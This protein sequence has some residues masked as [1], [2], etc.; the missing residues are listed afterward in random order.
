[1]VEIEFYYNQI[2]TGI[3]ANINDSFEKIFKKYI[4][5]TN[6]DIDNVYFLSNG[7]NVNKTD[8]VNK[9]INGP[10]KHNK[11]MKILVYPV[12][13]TE[14]IANSNLNN[15]KS[16]AIICP[17]CG[18]LCE[19]EIEKYKIKLFGCENGHIIENQYLNEFI[20]T[21]NI[22]ISKIK[23]DNCK[24]NNKADTF[25]NEFYF[26]YKCNMNL[27]PLCKSVHGKD[28]TIINYDSKNYLCNK[29]NEIFFKYCYSCQ[30]DI[31]LSCL[32]E[33]KNHSVISFEEKLIDIDKL[34]NNMNNLRNEIN[35]FREKI[36]D[37][38]IKLKKIIENLDLYYNINN[39]I[40]SNYEKNKQRNFKLLL[41]LNHINIS[42]DKELSNLTSYNVNFNN[43]LNTFLTL[44][45]E[46]YEEKNET[47]TKIL[48]NAQLNN[49]NNEKYKEII[50]DKITKEEY[51]ELINKYPPIG[52]NVKVE[53]RNPQENIIEKF[54]YYGEW[55]IKNN[56][57]HG[58]GIQIWPDGAKYE[59]YWQND[60]ANIK[61]KL[62]HADGDI[63]EGEWADDKPNG[64]GIYKHIDGTI[65][66][67][68]WKDD[69]QNG[70]G[71]EYWTDGTMYEGE[72]KNGKKSG[73][74]KFSWADGAIYVGD[75]KDGD[76]H[77]EGNYLFPDKRQYIG[78]W[79]KNKFEGKGVFTWPDG[80]KY[81]GEYKNEKKEG[82]GIFEWP[83]GK[84]YKGYWKDGKQDGEGE[85]YD[86]LIEKWRKGIWKDGKRIEWIENE[87]D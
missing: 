22:D 8:T 64:Y 29:H 11:K 16:E 74:G 78:S 77:G 35:N 41:N 75:F 51:E 23:C 83:N 59:G 54:I 58:R 9:I 69:K 79:V 48:D 56:V 15:K 5:K 45:N 43:D 25:K 18:D 30:K 84:I 72:Y 76:I 27:C 60:M 82:Y 85:F 7:K 40:L 34:R 1:M 67:G 17:K 65:Y 55:D 39:N 4:S 66:E 80:R 52:D 62:I 10:E 53:I 37:I 70:K 28:H 73:K 33:H 6:L 87:N 3:Q 36:N 63:Y 46:I 24:N 42:I 49:D 44:Y 20:N 31:C 21:Q 68:E 47:S 38:I 61:G 50:T 12:N 19:I 57:R 26:C 81:E 71:K 86:P 32:N 13:T 2:K 14:N